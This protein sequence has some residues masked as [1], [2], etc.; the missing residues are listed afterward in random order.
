MKYLFISWIFAT[1]NPFP[2]ALNQRY[3]YLSKP[4][5][6]PQ[7][8]SRMNQV[9]CT[10]LSWPPIWQTPTYVLRGALQDQHMHTRSWWYKVKNRKRKIAIMRKGFWILAFRIRREFLIRRTSRRNGF[11][12]VVVSFFHLFVRCC[13][14]VCKGKN[15]LYIVEGK[16]HVVSMLLI[17]NMYVFRAD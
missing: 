15:V 11:L 12:I 6:N 2:F 8:L 9:L 16:V 14:C 17:E 7:N 13:V 1:W 10:F 5:P 4:F 3:I